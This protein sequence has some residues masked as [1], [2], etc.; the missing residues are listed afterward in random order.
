MYGRASASQYLGLQ[1]SFL[2]QKKPKFLDPLLLF[3]GVTYRTGPKNVVTQIAKIF[4]DRHMPIFK[5][6][7]YYFVSHA[8][9]YY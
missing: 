1:F 6:T 3:R 9:G 8:K 5:K 4:V 7:S 2:R